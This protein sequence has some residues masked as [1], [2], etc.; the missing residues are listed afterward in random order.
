MA[1]EQRSLRE[2]PVYAWVW[3]VLFLTTGG[4]TAFCAYTGIYIELRPPPDEAA[5]WLAF[6]LCLMLGY[7]IP[8]YLIFIALCF[9]F[10]KRRKIKN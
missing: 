6:G 2:H 1:M 9:C 7:S 10:P 3:W 8:I 4:W 5:G